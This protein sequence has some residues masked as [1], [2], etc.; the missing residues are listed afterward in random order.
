MIHCKF[1]ILLVSGMVLL[2][3][4]NNNFKTK[5]EN[6]MTFPELHHV[7]VSGILGDAITSSKEGRLTHFI[8]NDESE[9]IQLF[10]PAARKEKTTSGWR[11]EH[12]GKWLYAASRAA[13]RSG[14]DTLKTHIKKVA[15]Y[16]ISTQEANGYLG[17]N[18]ES[19]RMTT[20]YSVNIKS[21]DVWIHTYM[22]A[23]LLEVNKYFPDEKYVNA[24]KK[25]GDLMVATFM[26][27]DKSLAHNS[28]HHGM[29]GTGSLDAFVE[30][31][32]TT[33][34]QK[35]LDFALYCADQM[36]FRKGLELISRSLKGYDVSLIG[37]GK[38]YEMLRNFV[39]LA[40]LYQVTGDEKYLDACLHAWK[41]IKD[42]HLTPTGGPWGGIEQHKE[43]FNIGYMFSP[44]GLVETC[45]TMDWIRLNK[46]LLKITGEARF[47]EE[48]ETSAYNAL[49]GARFPDGHSWIYYSYTN[50]PIQKTSPWA[51]CS[52]SGMVALEE[53]PEVLYA[54]KQ[55]GIAVN[56][57][58]PSEVIFE[59]KGAGRTKIRQE[60]NYPFTGEISLLMETE[61]EKNFPLYLRMPAWVT[62][63]LI[64]TGDGMNS[65]APFSETYYKLEVSG[66]QKIKIHFEMT[67]RQ[68]E[69]SNEYNHLGWYIDSTEYYVSFSRGPLVYAAEM[70][71]S[72][73]EPSKFRIN[74][75]EPSRYLKESDR[76][77]GIP[78]LTLDFPGKMHVELLPY[79]LCGNQAEGAFRKTWFIWEK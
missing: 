20:N 79:Y 63:M 43:C 8:R 18:A 31:Y 6:A 74:V 77:D 16:L 40:K 38:I 34:E 70:E 59:L 46:E 4:C 73:Q 52:S 76:K 19:I 7:K 1:C 51:C 27:T 24:A 35:Y 78:R 67:P 9:A 53:I 66:G 33:N 30:L 57:Y 64:E 49:S 3:S 55:E 14:D 15:D 39:G 12:A 68:T 75:E 54:R 22:M 23:G 26:N 13:Y 11:G 32:K 62:T 5:Q 71:D 2:F 72:Y 21:W 56:L 69:R 36:E 25:I 10:N 28:Y 61:N 17:T 60:G 29:V 48:L 42:H 50:G 44:Y 37:N 65:S 58:S 45:S 47:A 41:S